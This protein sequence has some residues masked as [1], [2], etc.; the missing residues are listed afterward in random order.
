M[1]VFNKEYSAEDCVPPKLTRT[2]GLT[3]GGSQMLTDGGA[4]G[5]KTGFLYHAYLRQERQRPMQVFSFNICR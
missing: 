3:L 4:N 2:V 1:N 5:R